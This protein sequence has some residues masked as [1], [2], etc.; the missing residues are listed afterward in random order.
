MHLDIYNIICFPISHVNRMGGNAYHFY[1]KYSNSETV[2]LGYPLLQCLP[3]V[4][5]SSFLV[6]AELAGSKDLSTSRNHLGFL[7]DRKLFN[8]SLFHNLF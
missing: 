5:H 6:S 2:W 8:F 3:G 1:C 4:Q 7:L